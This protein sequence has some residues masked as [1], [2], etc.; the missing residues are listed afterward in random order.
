MEEEAHTV[1]VERQ[2]LVNNHEDQD[3]YDRLIEEV[4]CVLFLA[5]LL[6][7]KIDL[8][9]R[10]TSHSSQVGFGR[11]QLFLLL[12]CGWANA[13]DAVEMMGVRQTVVRLNVKGILV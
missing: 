11:F 7:L 3:S 5:H 8:L 9:R 4:G 13:S 6:R 1:A 2:K 12:L 10:F